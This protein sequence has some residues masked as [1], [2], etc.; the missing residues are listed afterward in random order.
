MIGSENNMAEEEDNKLKKLGIDVKQKKS[1]KQLCRR[2]DLTDVSGRS[3]SYIIAHSCLSLLTRAK[4]SL[5]C[6]INSCQDRYAPNFEL[7][8]GFT[9]R[10][11]I[12]AQIIPN[13][14]S[15]GVLLESAWLSCFSFLHTFSLVDFGGKSTNCLFWKEI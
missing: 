2:R 6:P 1:L 12:R 9:F 13:L 7:F 11:C 5:Y 15:S 14:L 4:Y 3:I 8:D 10:A